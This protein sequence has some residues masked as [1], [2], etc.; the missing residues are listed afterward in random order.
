MKFW[1]R[2]MPLLFVSRFAMADLN[3]CFR[4]AQYLGHAHSPHTPAEDCIQKIDQDP[5]T[6]FS[7]TA[8]GKK[9]MGQGN[10]IYVKSKEGTFPMSGDQT[11]LKKISFLRYDEKNEIIIVFQKVEGMTSCSLFS[12]ESIG[13]IRPFV[14]NTDPQYESLSNIILFPKQEELAQIYESLGKIV[15]INMEADSRIIENG[16]KFKKLIKRTLGPD[17]GL[18]A[19]KFL[20]MNSDKKEIYV[21][22]SD[23]ILVFGADSD[24]PIRIISAPGR[25]KLTEMQF[26]KLNN[27]LI[28]FNGT[29]ELTP[30]NLAP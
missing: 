13:N 23:R 3:S 28:F 21:F 30:L 15:F 7:F 25:M 22:D 6:H 17:S 4:D 5:S 26:E 16:S 11:F 12:A 20:A 9:L 27:R 19:P 24:K 2:L 18:V 29:Q 14:F 10:L 8:S 1:I